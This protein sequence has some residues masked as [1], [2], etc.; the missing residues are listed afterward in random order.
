MQGM[1]FAIGLGQSIGDNAVEMPAIIHNTVRN[2]TAQATGSEVAGFVAADLA[3][4]SCDVQ[5]HE[6]FNFSGNLKRYCF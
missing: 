6:F 5:D 2:A 3:H 4:L 1:I